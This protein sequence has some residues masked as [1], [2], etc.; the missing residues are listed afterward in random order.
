MTDEGQAAEVEPKPSADEPPK[1]FDADYVKELRDENAG[2]RKK[3]R[4]LE[5]Q[6]AINRIYIYPLDDHS[7][8]LTDQNWSI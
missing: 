2:W 7:H 6:M 1:M 8:L 3:V 4:D 5:K